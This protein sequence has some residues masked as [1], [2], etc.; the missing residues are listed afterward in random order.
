M[1]TNE[2]KATC[3]SLAELEQSKEY[4]LLRTV[5]LEINNGNFNMKRFAAGI[6]RLHPTVQQLLFK[7]MKTC[8]LHMAEPGNVHIDDR[9]RCAYEGCRAIADTLKDIRLPLI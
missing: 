7:L 1:K 3:Y 2:T 4:H 9:N 5:A 6:G 8:A